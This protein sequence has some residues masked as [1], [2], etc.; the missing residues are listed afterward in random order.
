MGVEAFGLNKTRAVQTEAALASMFCRLLLNALLRSGRSREG[1]RQGTGP[2]TENLT[3]DDG[4]PAAGGD[5]GRR[6]GL[7]G[8]WRWATSTAVA[9]LVALP[10]TTGGHASAR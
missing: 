1:S 5:V 6:R 9:A 10:V 3:A 2:A 7:G 8:R 4:R